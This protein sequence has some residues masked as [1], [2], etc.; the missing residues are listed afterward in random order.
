MS[1]NAILRALAVSQATCLLQ[2]VADC[3][4]HGDHGG[5]ILGKRATKLCVAITSCLAMNKHTL[6]C[7]VFMTSCFGFA[8]NREGLQQHG[9]LHNSPVTTEQWRFSPTFTRPQSFSNDLRVS[10]KL[11]LRRVQNS[12]IA[13]QSVES[14]TWFC[15]HPPTE[16]VVVVCFSKSP[17]QPSPRSSRPQAKAATWRRASNAIRLNLIGQDSLHA[18][19]G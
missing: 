4:M 11:P 9:A 14:K 2:H 7:A 5:T 6:G 3:L 18:A 8:G 19:R 10:R 17:L 1:S 16:H 12:F 13:A 15:C